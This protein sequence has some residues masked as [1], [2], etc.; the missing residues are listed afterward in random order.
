MTSPIFG[1]ATRHTAARRRSTRASVTSAPGGY[2]WSHHSCLE[3]LRHVAPIAAIAAISVCLGICGCGQAKPSSVSRPAARHPA[4]SDVPM[5]SVPRSNPAAKSAQWTSYLPTTGSVC[6]ITFRIVGLGSNTSQILLRTVSATLHGDSGVAVS[7]EREEYD[8]AE[9]GDTE[10]GPLRYVVSAGRFQFE[11]SALGLAGAGQ[12]TS[13][14]QTKGSLPP[15]STF[16]VGS[17]AVE[18]TTI[19]TA[20]QS[21]TFIVRLQRVPDLTMRVTGSS[22]TTLVGVRTEFDAEGPTDIKSGLGRFYFAPGL[23]LVYFSAGGL[24]DVSTRCSD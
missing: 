19:Q 24:S 13:S 6:K 11:A 23:G 16:R 21:A 18:Y 7:E 8:V 2:S 20:G 4:I 14:Y 12:E 3:T 1:G 5:S 10:S 22:L 9:P 15:L 17:R